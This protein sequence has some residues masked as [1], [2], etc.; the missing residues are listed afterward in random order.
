MTSTPPHTHT[1]H[2]HPPP[3]HTHTYSKEK[4]NDGA[5][6]EVSDQYGYQDN[7]ETDFATATDMLIDPIKKNIVIHS[8]TK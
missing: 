7:T 5:P 8:F 4:K 1:R 3:P 6:R 2:H